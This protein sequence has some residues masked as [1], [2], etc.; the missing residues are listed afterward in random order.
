MPVT[1]S[2]SI[3]ECNVTIALTY[4]SRYLALECVSQVILT[5]ILPGMIHVWPGCKVEVSNV[6]APSDLSELDTYSVML[7]I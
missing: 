7:I 5:N 6:L 1:V 2:T 4:L 3:I